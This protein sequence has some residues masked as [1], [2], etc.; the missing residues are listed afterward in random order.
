LAPNTRTRPKAR[1][2]L[3]A[4]KM[5]FYRTVDVLRRQKKLPW[6]E[7]R[8]HAIA[9]LWGYIRDYAAY[10]NML[11]LEDHPRDVFRHPTQ[12]HS[13]MRVHGSNGA[14]SY[15]QACDSTEWEEDIHISEVGDIDMEPREYEGFRLQLSRNMRAS[16][17]RIVEFMHASVSAL[18]RRLRVRYNLDV[19]RFPAYIFFNSFYVHAQ[20]DSR[21]CFCNI[22]FGVFLNQ[23]QPDGDEYFE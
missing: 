23:R 4:E 9:Y 1:R 18:R 21:Y 7:A 5:K 8:L 22:H 13:L 16:A 10:D 11:I 3:D 20:P 12:A 17:K 6:Q 15:V 14:Y 19:A 2:F